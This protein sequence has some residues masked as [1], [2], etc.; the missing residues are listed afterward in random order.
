MF[1]KKS[2]VAYD[3]VNLIVVANK[4]EKVPAHFSLLSIASSLSL[5]HELEHYT[6]ITFSSLLDS[7]TFNSESYSLNV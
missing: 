4:L 3:T 7:L 5:P 6:Q 2:F 1:I